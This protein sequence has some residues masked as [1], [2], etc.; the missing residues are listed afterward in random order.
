MTTT[1]GAVVRDAEPEDVGAICRYGET[2][3]PSHYG[4]L[5]GAEAAQ[6]QVRRWWNETY[7]PGSCVSSA[8]GDVG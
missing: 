2:V 4:P 8:G 1:T 3:I 6:A 5:I 7:V